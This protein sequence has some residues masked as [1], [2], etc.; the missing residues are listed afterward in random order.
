MKDIK[1][2]MA[3]INSIIGDFAGNFLIIQD[4]VEKAK[5]EA[6]DLL[7]FPELAV[8]GYPPQDLIF[9]EE[10]ISRN[11]EYLHKIAQIIPDKM[12][13]IIGFVDKKDGKYYNSAALIQNKN[14][15]AVRQKTLLP[16]YDVF[17][18]KRYFTSALE[19]EPVE[20][21]FKGEKLSLGIEICEDLWDEDSPIKVTKNLVEKGAD[22]IINISASPF[23]QGKRETRNQLVFDKVK[24]FGKPFILV[25]YCGA[26]DE[27]IFAGNSIAC[28]KMGNIIALGNE[29]QEG[30]YTGIITENNDKTL[31]VKE[32]S[33]EEAI[34]NALVL[35]VRDYFRKTGHTKAVLGL[36]GGIDSALVAVVGAEAL[37]AENLT[38]IAMPSK[39]T[40]DMSNS[41]AKKL[42]ENLGA[43]FT[44][45]PIENIYKSF[46]NELAP[47]F[48]GMQEGLAE[49]N[50]Q[51]RTRGNIIMSVANKFGALMLNTGNKTELALGYCTMYGDM[52]GAVGVIGDLSKTEVYNVSRFINKKAGKEVIPERIITR[53]PSAELKDAQVDPFD[54]EIVSPLVDDI[55]NNGTDRESLLA[56]GYE[57]SV[58]DDC[59]RRIRFS[60]YKRKQAA[61]ALKVSR[62]AFGIGRRYPIVNKY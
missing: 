31:Q 38:C 39:Y 48:A 27:I 50:I 46:K 32:R 22:L 14:I 19:Q 42:A 3:Q 43:K 58:V 34:Y 7:I 61:P 33:I 13:C 29:F 51:A 60:E 8:S 23:E 21:E 54:Y 24:E 53:P 10:F 5:K 45:V 41:D 15:V 52:A 4:Y 2:R 1:I 44:S 20:V 56:K 25:N 47:L 11:Q 16:N 35:G 17:D 9:R 36:S 49:E 26:Q 18:E 55:I 37:G 28:D 40:S 57:A 12:L 59:L 6:V 30:F 62:K